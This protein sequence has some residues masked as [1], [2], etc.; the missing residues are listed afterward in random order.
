MRIKT[1]FVLCVTAVTLAGCF[2]GPAGPPGPPGPAGKDGVAGP[3]GPPAPQAPPDPK[4]LPARKAIR[5]KLPSEPGGR[6]SWRPLSF[7]M[8]SVGTFRTWRSGRCRSAFGG[9]GSRNSGAR[10]P[11]LSRSALGRTD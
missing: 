5:Q 4:G 8:S 10:C 6:L 2:E 7:R 9:D 3:P 1:L 11:L